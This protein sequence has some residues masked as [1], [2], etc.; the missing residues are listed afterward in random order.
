MVKAGCLSSLGEGGSRL[1]ALLR[2]TS[3]FPLFLAQEIFFG[4]F[5]DENNERLWRQAH[6]FDQNQKVA[7]TDS[8]YSEHSTAE[9]LKTLHYLKKH[10]QYMNTTKITKRSAEKQLTTKMIGTTNHFKFK[11]LY[12]YL[13][14]E[15]NQPNQP[16]TEKNNNTKPQM[17]A[18]NGEKSLAKEPLTPI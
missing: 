16:Q 1:G 12:R 17:T 3:N 13:P 18:P 7:V 4:L 14:Q 9:L 10:I 15:T 2:L 8:N 6:V 5:G 11:K